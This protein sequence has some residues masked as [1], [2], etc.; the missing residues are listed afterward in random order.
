MSRNEDALGTCCVLEIP[1]IWLTKNIFCTSLLCM[2]LAGIQ[3]VARLFPTRLYQHKIP[4]KSE[5]G[6]RC[7]PCAFGAVPVQVTHFVPW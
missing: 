7:K 1:V 4:D 5:S 3:V 2:S 6:K